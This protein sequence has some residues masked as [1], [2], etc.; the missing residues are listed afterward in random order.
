MAQGRALARRDSVLTLLVVLLLGRVCWKALEAR[1]AAAGQATFPGHADSAFYYTLAKNIASGRGAVVDYV[2]HFWTPHPSVTHFAA[3]YWM[4]LPS[5]LYAAAM[6]L[7]GVSCVVAARTSVVTSLLV[8]AASWF[9]ARSLRLPHW[10]S[11]L[12]GIAVFL[13]PPVAHFST[14]SDSSLA[15]T[16]FVLA[17]L[18]LAVRSHESSRGVWW[19]LGA[20]VASGA[21]QLCRNDGLLLL[22]CHVGA[23]V[24]GSRGLGS[25]EA[26]RRALAV[27]AGHLLLLAPY[28]IALGTATGRLL[29]AHGPLTFLYGFEDL[30]ALPPGPS[31]ADWRR[32]GFWEIALL[33]QLASIDRASDFV[34]DVLG[35]P[36]L[37]L[38]FGAGMLFGTSGG[39]RPLWARVRE[40]VWLGPVTYV[41][42][43]FAFHV[44]VT[45]V[46]SSAGATTRSLPA[47][48]AVLLAAGLTAALAMKSAAPPLL[49]A[50][51]LLVLWPWHER[52]KD[53]PLRVVKENNEVAAR[54][55]ETKKGLAAE[56][57]CL[58]QPIVVMTRDPWE[59]NELTGA[60]SVQ[61]P[62]GDL[63][64]I[65]DVARRYRVTH[66]IPTHRRTA[67]SD[68]ALPK[69]FVPVAGVNNLLRSAELPYECGSTP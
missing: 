24:F 66:L 14:Q 13:S 12:A 41:L 59:V 16:V 34:R 22:A 11:L 63:A 17:S 62:N 26:R 3:D 33:R 5:F 43:L 28:M 25:G 42:A 1:W 39:E 58:K 29:P 19:M 64:A 20:G 23:T 61:I 38:V 50:L 53:T 52:G 10:A 40:S 46:S 6:K 65:L 51:G 37:V 44:L 49:L 36:A 15:Y 30:Y 18:G 56:A 32:R 48:L 60:A 68:P 45:P 57:S 55:A 47:V 54:M 9:F 21:A 8:G 2:W 67:L 27:A 69:S 31:F 4:P 35:L 7:W